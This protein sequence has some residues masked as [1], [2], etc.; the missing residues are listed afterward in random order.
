[1]AQAGS[2]TT[3]GKQGQPVP[4]GSGE[5]EELL[6]FRFPDDPEEDTE[7]HGRH[8]AWRMRGGADE[9]IV[10]RFADH[11]A[12]AAEGDLDR[13]ADDPRG[14]LAPIVLLDQ[15]PRSVWRDSPRA[16]AQDPGALALALE[17]LENGHF[18]AL[19]M[20]W[21]RTAYQLSL[22]H[23]EG[24]DHIARLDRA[25]ALAQAIG[26]GAP[27]RLKPFYAFGVEQQV[28]FRRIVEAYGRYPHR[29]AIL[30]RASTPEEEAY[31]ASGRFPPLRP[32]PGGGPPEGG[33]SA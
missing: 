6:R 16:F 19:Q 21:E 29:N 32:V 18:E 28:L 26:D 20:P 14:R 22:G 23:C 7:A 25:R 17:G 27:D 1:M 3:A 5:W 13:W 2:G 4:T 11:T 10:A 30:G 9:K 31:V 12:R 15:F 33:G 24:P 8:W